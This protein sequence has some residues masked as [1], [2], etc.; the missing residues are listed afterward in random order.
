MFTLIY[1]FGTLVFSA[2]FIQ[3]KSHHS[4]KDKQKYEQTVFPLF[5]LLTQQGM[6]GKL[7]INK[8]NVFQLFNKETTIQVT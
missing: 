8:E 4:L 3:K 1:F 5:S 6:N 7:N 2:H